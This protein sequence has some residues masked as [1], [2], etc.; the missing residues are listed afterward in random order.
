MRQE[1]GHSDKPQSGGERGARENPQTQV[2]QE[3]H[4][5]REGTVQS[6]QEI[7]RAEQETSGF[8]MITGAAGTH[9]IVR[10]RM[11]VLK[12]RG[13]PSRGWGSEGRPGPGQG[14]LVPRAVSSTRPAPAVCQC[15]ATH[16]LKGYVV[17]SGMGIHLL[18]C[19]SILSPSPDGRL[20]TEARENGSE[21]PGSTLAKRN[22]GLF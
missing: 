17:I 8:Q 20:A 22:K 1:S 5:S 13:G 9:T 3:L 12:R 2:G 15:P 4:V 11:E 19:S 14:G 16:L 18:A 7:S 10:C 6:L 21:G